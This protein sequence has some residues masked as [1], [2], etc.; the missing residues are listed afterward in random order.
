MELHTILLLLLHPS[1]ISTYMHTFVLFFRSFGTDKD[2]T[3]LCKSETSI[4]NGCY[5][6]ILQENFLLL[7]TVGNIHMTCTPLSTLFATSGGLFNSGIK[8]QV[9]GP[10]TVQTPMLCCG[11][12]SVW[13][14]SWMCKPAPSPGMNQWG[15]WHGDKKNLCNLTHTFSVAWTAFEFNLWG[16][17]IYIL[18]LAW[19]ESSLKF[20]QLC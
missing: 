15:W 16:S 5:P 14:W 2:F 19:P 18:P 20:S 9:F 10:S 7:N 3:F 6:F 11:K 1:H 4:Q 12:L 13:Q 17:F 8:R